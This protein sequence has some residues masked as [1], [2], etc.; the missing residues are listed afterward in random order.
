MRK[1]I[2]IHFKKADPI[3]H[4]L[5]QK[6]SIDQIKPSSDL[7]RSLCREIIG[8]QLAGKA[9]EAI[10]TRF[11][12]LFPK[13]KVT[14]RKLLLLPD[15][16]VRSAGTSWAKVRSLKD[17]AKNVVEKNL[18]LPSLTNLSNDDVVK[19]LVKVKGIG[20]WTAEMFLMF[21]LARE[22]IFSYGDLGLQNAIQKLYKLPH[23]PTQKQLQILS[24][25]WSPYRTFAC[26][27]LWESLDTKVV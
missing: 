8:Q 10:C 4:S 22:D 21:S 5:I 25:K 2:V 14:A 23:K 19:E 15:D 20:P 24:K 27:L 17:L 12:K 9:A 11:M 1:D 26:L 13:G 6:L 18:H 3:L 16:A 7:F